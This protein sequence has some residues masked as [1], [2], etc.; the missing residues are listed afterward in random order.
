MP[1]T[2]I[3]KNSKRNREA[4]NREEKI[5]VYELKADS[6]QL[7]LDD[8]ETR[9]KSMTD[10]AI[11][12]IQ[13]RLQSELCN[14]KMSE[15]LDI[16]SELEH[17]DDF[18]ASDQTQHIASQSM[19]SNTTNGG[20]TGGGGSAN[21]GTLVTNSRNDEGYLTE[22]SSMG[23]GAISI[24]GSI[25]N[26]SNIGSS[27]AMSTMSAYN[28]AALRS[29]RAM[30]TPGPLH[31]ARARR[32]RRS[33]SACGIKLGQALGTSNNSTTTSN[34]N[35]NLSNAH[36]N[37]RSKLRT[38]MAARPKAFSA[39]R[40]SRKPRPSSSPSTPPM[41]FLRWPKPGEVA[42]SQFGSPIVAQVMPDK[43]A[44]VN[45]PIRNGVLSLRPR[46]LGEIKPDLLENLDAD[47]LS[48]IKTLHENLQLIV[49]TASK[50]G[51]K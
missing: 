13:S 10:T 28:G 39:D 37:S 49:D 48:Q 23:G 14:M 24:S 5:R 40:T 45:I 42:L 18:K 31:S 12:L 1:R 8:K 41:A 21:C 11:Q 25:N 38:P 32:E 35:S 2:K 16:I 17:F 50:A 33:R 30:R 34:S 22:D 15:F 44:N 7:A 47:T 36:R 20:G 6:I 27:S 9:Y 4:A 46:K 26:N 29:A 3:P 43:F 19:C 51:L